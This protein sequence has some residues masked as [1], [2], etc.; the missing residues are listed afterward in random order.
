MSFLPNTFRAKHESGTAFVDSVPPAHRMP[1]A[2]SV[3]SEPSPVY[4]QR[5]YPPIK[6]VDLATLLK[7]PPVYPLPSKLTEKTAEILAG[8]KPSN[9]K[10]I[11]G[12][13][14]APMSTVSQLVLAEVGVSMLEGALKY[15]RHNYR[16]VGV[17]ASVYFDAATRHLR[18]WWE[19]E[20]IDKAS[21][22]SH[23][24][25]AI[26]SLIVLRDAMIMDKFTDD[27][28]PAHPDIEKFMADLD[29]MAKALVARDGHLKPLHYTNTNKGE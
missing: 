28:P 1:G 18:S 26:T 19:G 2:A 11:M 29:D 5:S 3:R 17:L 9:P 22:L 24:T 16:A 6:D 27:R 14:K 12:T 20:D 21:N 25:K 15:G 7:D 13:S 10:D 8:H 23:I 4:P